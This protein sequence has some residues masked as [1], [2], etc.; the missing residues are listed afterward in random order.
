MFDE[1]RGWERLLYP[2]CPVPSVSTL[3]HQKCVKPFKILINCEFTKCF[4]FLCLCTG[5]GQWT[6]Q[7]ATQ[8]SPSVRARCC[9]LRPPSSVWRHCKFA[10]SLRP[11]V[12]GSFIFSHFTSALL[13]GVLAHVQN[14]GSRLFLSF[15]ITT[16]RRLKVI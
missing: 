1:R 5:K 11:R 7:A 15:Y 3:V 12:V 6:T 13:R 16:F 14:T 2:H 4:V 10:S 9:E 8:L